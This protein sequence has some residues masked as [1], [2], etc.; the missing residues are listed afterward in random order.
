MT[1]SN[2]QHNVHGH[3]IDAENIEID[4]LDLEKH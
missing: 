4:L 1:N 3:A 2:N